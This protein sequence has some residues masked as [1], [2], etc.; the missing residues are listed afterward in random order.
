[1]GWFCTIVLHRCAQNRQDGLRHP[2]KA[3]IVGMAA[4]YRTAIPIA[5]PEK[6][7]A[8]Q[9]IDPPVSTF[10]CLPVSLQDHVP[11]PRTFGFV[12]VHVGLGQQ[13][14]RQGFRNRR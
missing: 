4:V 11:P 13:K 7:S 10:H 3:Q 5:C 1:M 6:E 14:N 9:K 2:Q 8:V 12:V